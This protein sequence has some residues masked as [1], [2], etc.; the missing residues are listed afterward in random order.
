MRDDEMMHY[1]D[2]GRDYLMHFGIPGQKKGRR[3][4]QNKDGSLT[5]EGYI[6]YGYGLPDKE[7]TYERAEDHY[8]DSDYNRYSGSVEGSGTSHYDDSRDYYDDDYIDATYRE[9]DDRPKQDD[10]KKSSG[11]DNYSTR[12]T[13]PKNKSS[14]REGFV[15]TAAAAQAVANG[16]TKD[17]PIYGP[18]GKKEGITEAPLKIL[19][20]NDRSKKQARARAKN[21][22]SIQNLTDQQL[23]A[24]IDRKRLENTYLDVTTPEVQSGYDKTMQILTTVGAIAGTSLAVIQVADAVKKMRG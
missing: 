16:L 3:R 23:Q 15:T 20:K 14:F 7:K 22:A 17:Q 19:A 1:A 21:A 2:A 9:V 4:W 13:P 10:K 6:H 8:R 24:I 18:N 11:D 5:P 12:N